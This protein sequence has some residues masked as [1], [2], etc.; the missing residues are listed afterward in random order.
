MMGIEAEVWDIKQH[1]IDIQKKMDELMYERD[2]T[3]LMKLA[4]KSVS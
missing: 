3:A 2:I 4:E 1:I